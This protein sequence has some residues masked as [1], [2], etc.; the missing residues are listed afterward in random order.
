MI[1]LAPYPE[2]RSRRRDKA[3]AA[4]AQ[5]STPHLINTM[6]LKPHLYNTLLLFILLASAVST[7]TLFFLISTR[8]F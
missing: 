6:K 1:S 8:L 5:P 3:H 7:E 4:S 2:N